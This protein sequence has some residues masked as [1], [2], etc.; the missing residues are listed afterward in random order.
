MN[1]TYLQTGN[2][3]QKKLQDKD[4]R[5]NFRTHGYTV[6]RISGPMVALDLD[7]TEG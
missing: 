6:A 2:Q 4:S 7:R 1:N 5:Q 3:N